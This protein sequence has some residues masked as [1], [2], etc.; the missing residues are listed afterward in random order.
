[1][2]LRRVGTILEHLK[3]K[4]EVFPIPYPVSEIILQPDDNVVN[5]IFVVK[6]Q[7]KIFFFFSL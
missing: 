3:Y 5:L 2:L 4:I 6:I 1:M 7:F